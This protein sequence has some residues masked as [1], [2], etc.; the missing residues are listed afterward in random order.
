M[1]I[2]SERPSWRRVVSSRR[3]DAP[4]S[5]Q[6]HDEWDPIF[7][8]DDAY[9]A[10]I[11][12]ARHPYTAYAPIVGLHPESHDLL[13]STSASL[14][15][16]GPSGSGK[17]S[18]L[19]AVCTMTAPGPLVAWSSRSDLFSISA[20][21]RD[22][23]GD[24]WVLCV[25]SDPLFGAKQLRFSPIVPGM[26]AEEALETGAR[27]VRYDSLSEAARHGEHGSNPFFKEKG[28][29]GAG[30]LIYA[31][32]NSSARRDMRWAYFIAAGKQIAE[33]K[34][35]AA[36]LAQSASG[37]SQMIAATLEGILKSYD[38]EL[39]GILS[40]IATALKPWAFGRGY[41][42]QVDPNFN[43]KKFVRVRY[44]ELTELISPDTHA[45]IPGRC[46]AVWIPDARAESR[47]MPIQLEFVWQVTKAMKDYAEE[48]SRAGKPT[49]LPLTIAADE[50]AR[51]PIPDVGSLL[52]DA[53]DRGLVL[54]GGIQ[55][56]SQARDLY[57]KTGESF[58]SLWRSSLIF[59]GIK[60]K[61][62]LEL[63]SMLTRRYWHEVA[64]RG[65]QRNSDHNIEW[66]SSIS[67]QQL[68]EM[69]P[70]E[71]GLGHG[72]W[73]NAAQWLHEDNSWDWVNSVRYY[74]GEPWARI[75]VQSAEFSMQ[76][77]DDR[78]LPPLPPLAKG[79]DY[80]YLNRLGLGARFHALQQLTSNEETETM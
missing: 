32:A 58:L 72:L 40:M 60:D 73:P 4:S 68:P 17:T 19:V 36:E 66:M 28:G 6:R 33:L 70:D 16:L 14:L 24:N 79:G 11:N 20:A 57:G 22:R 63:I 45:P 13:R 55:D 56:L 41:E 18:S 7:R 44:A 12:E 1:V 30:C 52:S 46:D 59:R 65:Q 51:A 3:R 80:A 69:S 37:D 74:E 54:I 38:G 75:L 5:Q 53:R 8:S 62:T 47:F 34:A 15:A 10:V 42:S 9:G 26:S 27:L 48:L 35:I 21:L 78:L 77:R 67:Y 39:S 61:E 49:P 50:L 2:G 23:F 76:H 71:V 25:N 31:A 29:E 64:G 43:F